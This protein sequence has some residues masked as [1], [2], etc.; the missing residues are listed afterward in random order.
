MFYDI[1]NKRY[2]EKPYNDNDVY[3]SAEIF[4]DESIMAHHREVYGLL[5]L[6]GDVGGEI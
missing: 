6:F 1:D 4:M 2:T 5:E 3:F